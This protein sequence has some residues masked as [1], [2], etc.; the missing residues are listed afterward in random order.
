MNIYDLALWSQGAC[1]LRGLLND[2]PR[3][4]QA[5]LDEISSGE[6]TGRF[7]EHPALVLLAEQ[8]YYLTGSGRRYDQAYAYCKAKAGKTAA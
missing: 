7:E 4:R 5:V 2:V 6:W 3:F 1:N 8:I